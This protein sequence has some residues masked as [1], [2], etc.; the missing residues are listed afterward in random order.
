L[1]AFREQYSYSNDQFKMFHVA[2][3][4]LERKF[5]KVLLA[6][7]AGMELKSSAKES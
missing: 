1:I 6:E 2:R 5:E 4:E 7:N 3:R